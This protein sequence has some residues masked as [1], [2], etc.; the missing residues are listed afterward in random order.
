M[1]FKRIKK[2]KAYCQLSV[3]PTTNVSCQFFPI[4]QLT[5][6]RPL[7]TD[8]EAYNDFQAIE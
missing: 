8:K 4:C 7:N 5:P 3:K 6:F 2:A 1:N